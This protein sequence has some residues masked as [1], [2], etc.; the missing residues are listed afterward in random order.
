MPMCGKAWQVHHS[1]TVFMF[2]G[3]YSNLKFI[4]LACLLFLLHNYANEPVDTAH[5]KKEGI[6]IANT[7]NLLE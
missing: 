1:N 7:I 6:A 2:F 4:I 3:P 5:Q